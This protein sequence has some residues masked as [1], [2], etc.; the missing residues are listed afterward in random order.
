M[1][2]QNTPITD[3]AN[4]AVVVLCQDRERKHES[5]V[6]QF[7]SIE[8]EHAVSDAT[9]RGGEAGWWKSRTGDGEWGE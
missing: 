2:R 8:T 3:P 1:T 4:L 6:F 7:Q 5:I 9:Y